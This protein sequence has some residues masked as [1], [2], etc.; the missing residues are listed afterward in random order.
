M[1]LWLCYLKAGSRLPCSF[2]LDR[3]PIQRQ[4]LSRLAMLLSQRQSHR[5]SGGFV[6]HAS[7]RGEQLR[8]TDGLCS[9]CWE[10][11]G[12]WVSRLSGIFFFFFC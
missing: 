5:P 4:R 12:F 10:P 8:R 3:P 7:Y 2:L 9:R 1:E 6:L 11:D